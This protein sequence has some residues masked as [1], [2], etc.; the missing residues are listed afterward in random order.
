MDNDAKANTI[1][2]S[3]IQSGAVSMTTDTVVMRSMIAAIL[4]AID[5]VEADRGT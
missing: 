5:T 3:L 1:T 2:R 4:E